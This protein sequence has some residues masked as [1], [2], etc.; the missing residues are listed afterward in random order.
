MQF[1]APA[2]PTAFARGVIAARHASAVASVRSRKARKRSVVPV[3]VT[4]EARNAI[5][6]ALCF[7]NGPSP[8]V[9][10]AKAGA[11]PSFAQL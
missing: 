1:P 4:L 3:R 11:M 10:T 9:P 5:R 2:P 8:M 7:G 6:V